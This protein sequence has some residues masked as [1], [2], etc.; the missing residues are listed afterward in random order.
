M[1][2]GSGEDKSAMEKK[3]SSRQSA[4]PP[5]GNGSECKKTDGSSNRQTSRNNRRREGNVSRGGRQDGSGGRRPNPPKPRAYEKSQ[6]HN[7]GNPGDWQRQEVGQYASAELGS[8]QRPGSKKENLTHLLNFSF[9]PREGELGGRGWGGAGRGTQW[10]GHNR[11]TG[12]GHSFNKEQFLQA[13]C[14]FVVKEENDYERHTADPDLLVDWHLV[15]QVRIF[16]NEVPSCPVCLYPPVAARITRCGHIYCW[17]CMLHYL[18]LG[19]KSWGK[20]PICYE[21]IHQKDLKSVAALE[22]HAHSVGEEITMKLI[23]RDRG[24]TFALPRSQWR[25]RAG[26]PHNVRDDV[27]TCYAKLLVASPDQVQEILDCERTALECQLA[28]EG[29]QTLEGSYVRSALDLLKSRRENLGL[30]QDAKEDVAVMLQQLDLTSSDSS[31]QSPQL[32]PTLVAKG[33]TYSDAF[34]DVVEDNKDEDKEIAGGDAANSESELGSGAV[35]ED[36]M[37]FGVDA[38]GDSLQYVAGVD[39]EIELMSPVSDECGAASD[40]NKSAHGQNKLTSTYYYYQAMDGQQVYLNSVNARCLV[41]EYGSWEACP[42]VITAK[43]VEIDGCTMDADLRRRLRYLG[44]LPLCCEFR[45]AELALQ[46]PLVSKET[47][48]SFHAEIDKRHRA[49]QRKCR[50]DRRID[51]KMKNAE[52]RMN[53]KEKG[54]RVSLGSAVHF[55]EADFATDGSAPVAAPGPPSIASSTASSPVSSRPSSPLPTYLNPHAV[56]FTPRSFGAPSAVAESVEFAPRSPGAGSEDGSGAM[57]FAR[58]LREGKTQSSP[59]WP[60]PVSR[61]SGLPSHLTASRASDSE[62]DSEDRVP[63]PDYK[64]S[65][66]DAFQVA[67]DNYMSTADTG[68]PNVTVEKAGVE[69]KTGGKKKKK[70]QKQ[71]LLFST[72]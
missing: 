3:A 52:D 60:R 56:E 11:W 63:V 33:L 46:P 15:E 43:I 8:A 48:K 1:S 65:I 54:L 23:K 59:A 72:G 58:M 55:P 41:N 24:S 2:A 29:D 21:A 70:K 20:C 10:K 13:N 6:G 47:L 57:S 26:K 62:G 5:K 64:S 32:S 16:S 44:H 4:G 34:D 19:E 50:E 45:V 14:Q 28:D 61:P 30:V 9:T 37:V 27:D 39:E 49:R 71:M 35:I 68:G 7:R 12:K 51:K 18:S 67:M 22:R 69:A 40:G 38:G 25:E 31:D 36:A 42:D 17:A 66:G 53:G